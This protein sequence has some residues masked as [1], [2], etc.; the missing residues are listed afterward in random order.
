MA[1]NIA[2]GSHYQITMFLEQTKV[3]KQ[4]IKNSK[5]DVWEVRK[6]ALWALAHI[7][8]SGTNTHAVSLVNAGGLEPLISVLELENIEP[9]LLLAILDAL[10]NILEVGKAFGE[11]S[12]EL[13]IEENNGIGYLEELQTH[14]SEIVYEKVIG[15]I[16]DYFGVEDEGDEN[17]APV[18][19]ESGMYGFGFA[20]SLTS[21]KQLFPTD[22]SFENT[23]Q[24]E[25]FPF[26][27]VS[28]N[29]F[30]PIG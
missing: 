15:L 23:S 21:P 12:Y 27:D 30:Y 13:I 8:T 18:T 9:T 10:R 22:T 16:E 2:C 7:C 28:T 25:A 5:R 14:P 1:S 26:G 11:K 19:N 3:L 24:K 17:L 4:I 6:E 20:S 29:T